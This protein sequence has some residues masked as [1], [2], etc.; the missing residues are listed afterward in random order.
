[1][2]ACG[3]ELDN[4]PGKDAGWEC[5]GVGLIVVMHATVEGKRRPVVLPARA[6]EIIDPEDWWETPVQRFA[7]GDHL[8]LMVPP[9]AIGDILRR[10]RMTGWISDSDVPHVG[11]PA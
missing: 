1:V 7:G 10:I 9:P 11:G 4:R 2:Q 3:A 5:N 8:H 6:L